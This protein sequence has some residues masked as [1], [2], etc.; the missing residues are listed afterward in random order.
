MKSQP[1]PQTAFPIDSTPSNAAGK[2]EGAEMGNNGW[3]PISEA[4][5]DGTRILLFYSEH[6]D[7][8]PSD[9]GVGFMNQWG[10][11]SWDCWWELEFAGRVHPTHF[12]PLP[13]PPTL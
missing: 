8:K 3:K 1:A 4:P 11:D 5:K 10:D 6:K 2:V 9:M 12:Q 7:G 13:E